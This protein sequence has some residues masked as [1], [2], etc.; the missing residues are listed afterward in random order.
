MP[1]YRG[2]KLS[3]SGAGLGHAFLRHIERTNLIVHLLDLYPPDNSDPAANYRIIRQELESFSEVLAEKREIIV[4]N[5]VDLS[6]DDEALSKLRRSVKT[7]CRIHWPSSSIRR[8]VIR[9][10]ISWQV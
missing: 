5:K 9:P 1:P 2:N 10:A 7:G 4:A 3:Q 8:L 6:I